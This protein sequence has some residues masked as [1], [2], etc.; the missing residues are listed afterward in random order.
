[1]SLIEDVVS[2]DKDDKAIETMVGKV[3]GLSSVMD[4]SG[5]DKSD[6]DDENNYNIP[7]MNQALQKLQVYV[8][9][10]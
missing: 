7:M 5:P 2:G 8:R 3:A 9:G 1:M 6:E 4:D 10:T